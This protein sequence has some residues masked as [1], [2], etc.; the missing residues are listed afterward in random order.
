M[1]WDLLCRARGHLYV[2]FPILH[3]SLYTRAEIFQ[4]AIFVMFSQVQDNSMFN[5]CNALSKQLQEK[6]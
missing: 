6:N 2:D 4:T 5:G 1:G 3:I